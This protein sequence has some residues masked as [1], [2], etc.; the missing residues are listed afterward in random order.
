MEKHTFSR[1]VQSGP[2]QCR[3]ISMILTILVVELDVERWVE[4]LEKNGFVC[5]QGVLNIHEI[6]HTRENINIENSILL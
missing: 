1:N 6:Q 4:E 5:L 3:V 2:T